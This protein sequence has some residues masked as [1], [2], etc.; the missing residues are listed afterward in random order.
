MFFD[1]AGSTKL[2]KTYP[3]EVV[4]DIKNTVIRYVIEIIQA[5]DG[6]VHRIMGDA[7]MA[8]FRSNKKTLENR[9]IDSGIDA[10]NAGIYILEFMEQVVRPELGDAQAEHPIGVRVGIDYAKEEDIVWGN[11]GTSGAFEVTATSYNVDVAAKLQQAAGTDHIMIGENLKVL[12]G[13]GNEYLSVPFRNYKDEDGNECR[14]DYPYVRPNYRVRGE[15]I[16]YKQYVLDSDMY[17]TFL[18]YG[19]ESKNINVSLTASRNG[20]SIQYF[21]PC[22]ESLDKGMSLTFHVTYNAPPQERF[23]VKSV[24]KNT[25]PEARAKGDTSPKTRFKEMQYYDSAWHADVTEATSYHG[26]HH[27][28]IIILNENSEKVDETVFSIYIR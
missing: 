13:L 16:N 5:F 20:T 10:I 23:T 22:A 24:K 26:L 11:Y 14:R 8:F 1:I 3:P 18:P 9:E 12:L 21:C 7:V 15:Q 19:I 28:N 6:H 27:M 2:G 25:G 4:F 17:F